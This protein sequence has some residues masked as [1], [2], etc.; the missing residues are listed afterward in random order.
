MGVGPTAGSRGRAEASKR[1]WGSE[2]GGGGG[3]NG[4]GGDS[5]GCA[6]SGSLTPVP[7]ESLVLIGEIVS[8]GAP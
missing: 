3:T 5:G 7:V 6:A 8:G 1:G 4:A 2:S